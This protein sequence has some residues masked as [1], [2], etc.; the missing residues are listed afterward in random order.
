MLRSLAL[1]SLVLGASPAAAQS[2]CEAKCNQQASECLKR[3]TGDPKDAQ[4]P[5]AG[6]KL[7]DCLRQCEAKTLACKDACGKK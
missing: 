5:E 6:Q 3:C 1:L 7:M 2:V 4:K